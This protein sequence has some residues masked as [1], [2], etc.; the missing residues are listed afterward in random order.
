MIEERLDPLTSADQNESALHLERYRWAATR[1]H[2]DRV[3]DAACGVGYGAAILAEAGPSVLGVDRDAEALERARI[4]HGGERVHFERVEDL[5]APAGQVAG[6]SQFDT[7]VSLETIEHLAHPITFLRRVHGLLTPAGRLIVSAPVREQPGDNPYHLHCFTPD[8]LR[9]LVEEGFEIE[10]ELTQAGGAYLTVSAR[11]RDEPC[12]AWLGAE[13]QAALATVLLVTWNSTPE[14]LSLL[15]TIRAFTHRPYELVVVDND[16]SDGLRSAL[17]LFQGEPGYRL[18]ENPDNRRCAAATNQGL[19]LCQTEYLVYLCASHAVVTEAGWIAQLSSWM[20]DHPDVAIAGDTWAPGF[21]LPSKR[22]RPDWPGESQAAEL[23]HVQGGA[24]IARTEALRAIGGF[25]EEEHPHGGMDVELSYR[26][27]S[28]GQVLGACPLIKCP[29]SPA[30]PALTTGVLVLHPATPEIR[31]A[32]ETRISGRS[33]RLDAAHAAHPL[34]PGWR[35]VR[36]RAEVIE[37]G[38]HVTAAGSDSGVFS[39]RSFRDLRVR[40]KVSYRGVLEVKVRIQS[41]EDPS[42]D[43]YHVLLGQGTNYLARAGQV[44]ARFSPVAAMTDLMLEVRGARLR[45][46][47][48]GRLAADVTDGHLAGGH[49]LLGVNSGEATYSEV[50]VEDLGDSSQGPGVDRTAAAAPAGGRPR[51]I[52]FSEWLE[53][54]S[55]CAAI[56]R[57][58]SRRY[59]VVACGPGWG[60]GLQDVDP[61]GARFYLELDAA[62]GSFVR[63]D[64]LE[65]LTCPKFAWLIDTH[66]KIEF[67]RLIARKVNLTFFAHKAWGHVFDRPCAWLPL[68]ADQEIYHPIERERDLDLVFVGSQT[69]RADPLRAIA[70]RH[71]LR[72]EIATTTG[73]REKSETAALYA[74]SKL[75]FNRHVTNDLN[76]RVFEALAAGR[77]L[78]TDAQDN[79]QYELFEEERHLVLYKGE[80]DLER[81]ILRLLADAGL[82]GRIEQEARQLAQASHTTR[83]RV[84]QLVEAIESHLAAPVPAPS[85]AVTVPAP[86]SPQAQGCAP[87]P[88]SLSRGRW[89]VIADE[90]PEAVRLESYAERTATELK[91]LGQEVRIALARRRTLPGPGVSPCLEELDPG[92]LPIGLTATNRMLMRAPAFERRLAELTSEWRPDAI[93]AEGPLGGLLGPSLARRLDVPLVFLLRD[94]E[95][96]RR[97]NHL[98][99][100][101][102][103]LAELEQWACERSALVAVPSLAVGEAAIRHYATRDPYLLST[104]TRGVRAPLEPERLLRRLGLPDLSL[105]V[106]GAGLDDDERQ[107]VLGAARRRTTLLVGPALTLCCPGAAPAQ[108]ARQTPR[109]PALGALLAVAHEIHLAG[110][111]PELEADACAIGRSTHLLLREQDRLVAVPQAGPA[112]GMLQVQLAELVT[113]VLSRARRQARESEVARD[114]ILC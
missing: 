52:V 61:R 100:E 22:Y 104:A 99:R 54:E 75:V 7:V 92:P 84:G 108:L 37:R 66:K 1:L 94:C 33:C 11:R 65:D 63:P 40:A 18:I 23:L 62:S 35:V 17:R 110:G 51:V 57:E 91:E 27:Q 29:P 36:G 105:L 106:F 30:K 111:C 74:R 4:R 69:W 112:A 60:R 93:L 85:P 9:L 114:A 89:L 31:A 76:F 73:A 59:E 39:E 3:L 113:R 70:A 101:E 49:A 8:T 21:W 67:H 90:E 34:I 53:N 95:V 96:A 78:L 72:L 55:F 47:L 88:R 103:Y 109:G 44:L 19:A 83:A 98:T 48:D 71:G 56:V 79:G 107:A 28:Y 43:G 102:L 15:R 58:L 42:A 32:L 46:W 12:A 97:R 14:V 13:R 26:L 86:A 64:G 87:A 45:L 41:D 16:S 10:E 24:W 2:G 20:A 80:R 25:D 38:A 82:R 77:V 68:H 50:S 5:L 81:Q 6:T